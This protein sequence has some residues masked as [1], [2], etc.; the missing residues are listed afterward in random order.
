MET[1]KSLDFEF[2]REKP[3]KGT[4]E[5]KLLFG[6][7][8]IVETLKTIVDKSPE[9]FT[10]GLYGKWGVGKSTIAETL[11]EELKKEEIPLI[12]FDVWKHEGD[13]LRR[14]FLKKIHD[15]FINDEKWSKNYTEEK[16]LLTSLDNSI[17][18]EITEPIKL[19]S[20]AKFSLYL[21]LAST[22][23]V[24]GI[25]FVFDYYF[26]IIDLK[27][28]DLKGS[29]NL[30][31]GL[32]PISFLVKFFIIYFDKLKGTKIEITKG[33]TQDPF[34]FEK[35]FKKILVNLKDINKVVVVFDNL[36]RVSG[37]KAIEIIS[38]I[39]AFLDPVDK[40]LKERDVVFII[41]CDEKA[42]KKHL[43]YS[44]IID[45]EDDES[46][47][48]EYLKKFFNTIIWIPDFY[49]TELEKLAIL[50]L[51][52]TKIN[53][54]QNEDL[55]AL[56][57]L[58]FTENPR[59]IIQFVNIL[60][61]NY[62]LL[63]NSKINDFKIKKSVPQLAKYLLLRQFFPNIIEQMKQGNIY[64]L[65]LNDFIP[66]ES[67]EKL[68]WDNF[69]NFYY[70]TRHIE[71]E[72]F[73]IFFK[74]RKSEFENRFENSN[75]LLNEIQKVTTR[76]LKLNSNN[77]PDNLN[78]YIDNLKIKENLS[79]F[80]FIIREKLES[81]NNPTLKTRFIEGL[82]NLIDYLEINLDKKTNRKLLF[83]IKKITLEEIH[84]NLLVT[85]LI[86]KVQ[87]EKL[88]DNITKTLENDWIYYLR[89]YLDNNI[90]SIAN[91]DQR[92]ITFNPIINTL[93]TNDIFLSD[94]NKYINLKK[95]ISLRFK[96]DFKFLENIS[97]S[98]KT[99]NFLGSTELLLKICANFNN[100]EKGKVLNINDYFEAVSIL[101]RYEKEYFNKVEII[102]SSHNFLSN[103]IK[104]LN[105]L[106]DKG[107]F[108]EEEKSN[109]LE[110]Y[111]F[112]IISHTNTF[113]SAISKSNFKNL[114]TLI[115][116]LFIEN[117]KKSYM[118]YKF[119][120]IYF[121]HTKFDELIDK[122][123]IINDLKSFLINSLKPVEFKKSLNSTLTGKDIIKKEKLYTTLVNKCSS[124]KGFYYEFYEYLKDD[125]KLNIVGAM[126][127][128]NGNQNILGFQETLNKLKGK[129]PKTEKLIEV[130]LSNFNSSNQANEK[131]ELINS[132]FLLKLPKDYD[133]STI[134][135]L[136]IDLLINKNYNF[137]S[138]GLKLLNKYKELSVSSSFR[139][140][141]EN[142]LTS[143]YLPNLESHSRVL[144]NILEVEFI[145]KK[146]IINDYFKVDESIVNKLSNYIIMQRDLEMLSLFENLLYKIN[147]FNISKLILSSISS[148]LVSQKN[149]ITTYKE[150][151][152]KVILE[153]K[154]KKDLKANINQL[155]NSYD[156][157]F[158]GDE[159]LLI[160]KIRKLT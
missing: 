49:I 107:E 59:Q 102:E 23:I 106:Y 123:T 113:S 148:I 35:T 6:H 60:V 68:E 28:S 7:T 146:R 48:N 130:I 158:T 103:T 37:D 94:K 33:I 84:P 39:K 89:K 65:D 104:Q 145:K 44:L 129:I 95:S 67:I 14:T 26:E 34:E 91:S 80:Y 46:Y 1:D 137:S 99:R 61:A 96:D 72:S 105:N 120:Y 45:E 75:K 41:P 141:C 139:S 155:L 13:G 116:G 11:Q 135:N 125:D 10:I 64:R 51:K 24:F 55:S 9:S 52:K 30:L 16:N 66:I 111:L 157:N 54:F 109:E 150:L 43:K 56:I 121:N 38:T 101:N 154:Y 18:N 74:L 93:L 53:E 36:D 8:E 82:L 15:Y 77:R 115:R 21:F 79:D 29:V 142:S 76:N 87:D 40:D 5:N 132:I 126:V 78:I 3:L 70:L 57:S 119:Y 4:E 131:E 118:F 2:I 144:K 20:V 42:I 86:N 156:T 17:K 108:I 81:I 147:Y 19:W 100:I 114:Y 47:V 92:E 98:I 151:L 138:V 88:K 133:F 159:D 50:T 71:I 134:S 110:R 27:K 97:K 31:L 160:T 12:I 122:Q 143:I 83:N 136:A 128:L 152:E 63:L 153:N 22:F 73:D 25:W 127:P 140:K 149:K 85:Q 62:I 90:L 124:N 69:K 112:K 117:E 58:V 32:F